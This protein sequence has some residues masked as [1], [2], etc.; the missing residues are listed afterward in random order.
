MAIAVYL[1]GMFPLASKSLTDS[2]QW[3]LASERSTHRPYAHQSEEQR[4]AVYY[5]SDPTTPS[6]SKKRT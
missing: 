6:K 3:K 5:E 2:S 4:T 1:F